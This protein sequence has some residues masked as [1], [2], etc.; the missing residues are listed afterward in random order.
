MSLLPPE[1]RVT[2]KG[3]ISMFSGQKSRL[4][5]ALRMDELPGRRHPLKVREWE[6]NEDRVH[7]VRPTSCNA[8]A[9]LASVV[10]ESSQETG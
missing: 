6:D 5:T 9:V 2:N 10:E 1:I 4:Q 8:Q 3:V 7:R